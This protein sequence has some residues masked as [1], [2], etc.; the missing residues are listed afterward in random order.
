MD[1][2]IFG[3]VVD[4][5]CSFN[6]LEHINFEDFLVISYG[7]LVNGVFFYFERKYDLYVK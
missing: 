4:Y 7:R 2:R 3:P 5:F 6:Y 1:C